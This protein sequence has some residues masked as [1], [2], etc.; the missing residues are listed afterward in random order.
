[1]NKVFIMP[2]KKIRKITFFTFP[3]YFAHRIFLGNIFEKNFK[4]NVAN[5]I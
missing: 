3:S 5:F 4:L 1:M 2:D